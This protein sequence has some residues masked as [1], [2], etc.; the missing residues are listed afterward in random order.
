MTETTAATQGS[1]WNKS[2]PSYDIIDIIL[3]PIYMAQQR[4]K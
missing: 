1:F 3:I 4:L 2:D